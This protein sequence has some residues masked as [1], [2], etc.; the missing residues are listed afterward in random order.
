MEMTTPRWVPFAAYLLALFDNPAGQ[1]GWFLFAIFI[2]TSIGLFLPLQGE[3]VIPV[4]ITL[5][6]LTGL[7]C[8]IGVIG[9]AFG[10]RRLDLLRRGVP[11]TGVLVDGYLTNLP[12]NE[13]SPPLYKLTFVFTAADGHVYPAFFYTDHFEPAWEE[14]LRELGVIKPN[15]VGLAFKRAVFPLI[16]LFMSQT[17][18]GNYQY[19]LDHANDIRVPAQE[20]LEALVIYLPADPRRA[21]L[22]RDLLHGFTLD[23]TGTVCDDGSMRGYWVC[24]LPVLVALGCL[25]DLVGLILLRLHGR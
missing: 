16:R 17:E 2:P 3:T 4:R 14:K 12:R 24:I 18:I 1:V 15:T 23:D 8:V 21:R 25:A 9:A 20:E 11:V 5:S 6:I 13:D 19:R 10:L 7:L 22:A